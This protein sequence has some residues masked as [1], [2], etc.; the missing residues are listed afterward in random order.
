MIEWIT[1]WGGHPCIERALHGY[2]SLA[3]SEVQWIMNANDRREYES[4]KFPESVTRFLDSFMFEQG[5]YLVLRQC[6]PGVR[7]WIRRGKSLRIQFS[8]RSIEMLTE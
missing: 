4:T 6:Q 7:L 1:A 5:K 2:S 3:W 8:A